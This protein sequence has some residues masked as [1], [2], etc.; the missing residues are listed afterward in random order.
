MIKEN[1]TV[2]NRLNVILDGLW[3][4]AAL[5]LAYWFRFYVMPDGVSVVPFRS[6]MITGL[7]LVP[8]HLL[9]Y[10]L[11]GLYE[12]IRKKQ[13]GQELIKLAASNLLIVAGWLMILFLFKSINYSR[14]VM[15]L[16]FILSTGGL[17]LKR[18]VIYRVL[19]RYRS[20][21]YNQKHVLLAG[22]GETIQAYVK[23]I[24]NASYLGYHPIGYVSSKQEWDAL[25]CL[26]DLE[27]LEQILEERKPDEV[28]AGLDMNEY[29][30]MPYVIQ[31]CEKSGTKLSMIPFYV[32]YMPSNPQIDSI[33][34]LPLINLRRI[35]LDNVGNAF[36]KRTMDVVGALILIV[37]SSPLMLFAAVGVK[38]SSPGPIIFKQTR[39]G[40]NKKNFNMYKFR[41]MR[42][43]NQEN[44][45]WS[46]NVDNR[47]TKFGS[48]IRKTSIDELPQ[49][50]NVLKG[51]M[52]L[53]GPRPELPFFVEQLKEDVPLYMVKHQ[54]RPG[55]TGWAQV[56]GLRGDTSIPERI[57]HDVYYIE[58][59]SLAFDIKIL[60]MTIWKVVNPE[61]IVK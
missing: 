16:Y 27:H 47:K 34:G 25:P 57:R 5:L 10:G 52:S 11:L 30:K 24:T 36:L 18:I 42:V 6:Y 53:V 35:P 58:N 14:W 38:L 20:L 29:D 40:L 13:I 21:G 19:H 8:V 22:S 31:A 51:D 61:K 28:V 46:K 3:V 37:L 9:T 23:E 7:I 44:T 4:Y 17:C 45:G 2:L 33:N 32:K 56:N 26:G 48:L 50:F 41:S 54:V 39:V 15:A 59:W 1:Q 49:F 55:I 43:N 12:P 60:F